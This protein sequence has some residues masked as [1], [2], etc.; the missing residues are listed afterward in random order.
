MTFPLN[1]QFRDCGRLPCWEAEGQR[2]LGNIYISL[3]SPWWGTER[4]GL[5]AR[6]REC[7]ISTLDV[8]STVSCL[9]ELTAA[10]TLL[11]LSSAELGG[12]MP[13]PP[14]LAS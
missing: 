10:L 8:A 11:A 7:G 9:P 14:D 3:E 4:K 5:L 12:V 6:L 13:V 2:S 1:L